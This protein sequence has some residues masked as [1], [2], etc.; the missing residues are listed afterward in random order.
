MGV[1]CDGLADTMI[2]AM[3][4]LYDEDMENLIKWLVFTPFVG[5]MILSSFVTGSDAPFANQVCNAVCYVSYRHAELH[6]VPATP[7][8][9]YMQ[10]TFQK[11][12]EIDVRGDVRVI[13]GSTLSVFLEIGEIKSNNVNHAFEQL[14]RCLA[15]FSVAIHAITGEDDPQTFVLPAIATTRGAATTSEREL[16]V[17]R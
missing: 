14:H 7:F 2:K 15:V 10:P 3:D 1:D 13:E 4:A 12:L 17:M 16:V 9:L 8:R 5:I 6:F 11:D